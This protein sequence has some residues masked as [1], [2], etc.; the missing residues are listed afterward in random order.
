MQTANC[1][2]KRNLKIFQKKVEIVK[3]FSYLCWTLI[4]FQFTIKTLMI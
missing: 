4:I 1:N 2:F 3:S